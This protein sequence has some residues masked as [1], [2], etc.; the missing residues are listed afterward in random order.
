MAEVALTLNGEPYT[1]PREETVSALLARIGVLPE[2]VAVEIN[3]QIV[4]RAE[5][6]ARLVRAGDVVEIVSFV[7]GG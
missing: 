2:R 6:G 3:L 1:L 7:G 4:P 5:F